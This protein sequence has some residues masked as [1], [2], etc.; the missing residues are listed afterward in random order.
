VTRTI[1]VVRAAGPGTPTVA[2][3]LRAVDLWRAERTRDR[4]AITARVRVRGDD[5]SLRGH[6]PG[7][8]VFPGVYVIEAL[9]QAMALAGPAE[10][11]GVLVLRALTS[12]RFLAPL[13]DGDELT[14]DIV[15]TA[16]PG[17]G[18]A[19]RAEGARSDGTKTARIRA[20]F[21]TDGGTGA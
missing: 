18:W 1:E 9:R 4:L 20:V 8:V 13:M 11:A 19:V 21:D 15:A 7:L 12:V 17:C 2:A 10:G 3:P 5:P 14:L 6:F 16:R